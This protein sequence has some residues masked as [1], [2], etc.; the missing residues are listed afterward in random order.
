LVYDWWPVNEAGWWIRKD[1]P[2]LFNKGTAGEERSEEPS[3]GSLFSFICKNFNYKWGPEATN[4]TFIDGL[5]IHVILLEF[6]KR[7]D[8][9]QY[10]LE[11]FHD[12]FSDVNLRNLEANL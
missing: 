9:I 4:I 2:V 1:V 11:F 3:R 7:V 12:N 6:S 5:Y 10:L 8:F